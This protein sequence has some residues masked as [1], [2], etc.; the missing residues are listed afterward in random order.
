MYPY[1]SGRHGTVR[2][3][4]E[5]LLRSIQVGGLLTGPYLA[6]AERHAK[7]VAQATYAGEVN[8]IGNRES[9]LA[10]VQR[11][12][13]GLL[14]GIGLRLQRKPS[15]GQA[16]TAIAGQGTAPCSPPARLGFRRTDRSGCPLGP[17]PGT[18][19]SA[20]GPERAAQARTARTSAATS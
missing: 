1:R 12:V 13:G 3:R 20:G 16:A 19:G 14:V 9:P 17:P 15:V 10:A 6:V 4:E 18:P 8:L 5:D 2:L 7:L 11:L